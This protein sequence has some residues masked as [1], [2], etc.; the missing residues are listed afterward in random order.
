MNEDLKKRIIELPLLPSAVSRLIALAPTDQ[1]YFDKVLEIAQED[2]ALSLRIIKFANTAK[3]V[4]VKP[5]SSLKEAI[6]RIG[7][8]DIFDI[9]A[10][11]AVTK[12]FVPVTEEEKRIWLHS[13]EVA[14]LARFLSEH[15]H[16]EL[17]IEPEEAYLA[18][19]LHDIGLFLMFEVNKSMLEKVNEYHWRTP[20]QHMKAEK[21]VYETRHD[22]LGAFICKEWSIP[23]A[24]VWTVKMHHHY[25]LSE[26]EN[27]DNTLI[28]LTRIIQL[29]D[30]LSEY[31][32]HCEDIE[33]V[34]TAK[35]KH[36]LHECHPLIEWVA[37]HKLHTDASFIPRVRS[38]LHQAQEKFIN[39][40]L[41]QQ[42]SSE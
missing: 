3:V 32:Y 1:N 4:S 6:I 25:D 36:G 13:L 9:V 2:P 37:K 20:L 12:V 10:S 19:L 29:A 24:I 22:L 5:I 27:T 28:N 17:K 42:A 33:S 39:L 7:I 31:F 14:M 16:K 11:I 34:T 8:G 38:V 35:L 40:G 41:S 18:G 26:L 30:F 15:Y 21:E 23:A